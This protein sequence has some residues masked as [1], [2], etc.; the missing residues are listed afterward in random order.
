MHPYEMYQTLV[1]RG[2]DHHV[3]LRPGTLYHAVG[4]LEGAGYIL[5]TGV[6]REG[7]R[8]ER[9]TYA[10]TAEGREA[11]ALAVT[12]LITQPEAE[13]PEFAV[14]MGEVHNLPAET[15]VA[16]LAERVAILQERLAVGEAHRART[17]DLGVPR[18]VLLA[19]EFAHHRLRGDI[20]WLTSVIADIESGDLSWDAPIPSHIKEI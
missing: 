17:D 3:K 12:L 15:A 10:V 7:N 13:Y 18:R 6:E 8:P 20:A 9:T 14:A 1:A 16:L 2:Q 11:L 5:A 19:N 4:W